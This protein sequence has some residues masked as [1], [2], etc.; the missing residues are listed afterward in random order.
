MKKIIS[1]A[2]ESNLAPREDS[3]LQEISLKKIYDEVTEYI[4]LFDVSNAIIFKEI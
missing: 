4:I 2:N 1:F 3:N